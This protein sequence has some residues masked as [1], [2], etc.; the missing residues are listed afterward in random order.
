M[1]DLGEEICFKMLLSISTESPRLTE[2]SG[3]YAQ[4][5]GKRTECGSSW[6][7]LLSGSQMEKHQPYKHFLMKTEWHLKS[8]CLFWGKQGN[9]LLKNSSGWFFWKLFWQR[10]ETWIPNPPHKYLLAKTGHRWEKR[11]AQAPRGSAAA[12]WGAITQI[13]STDRIS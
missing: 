13:Y 7:D 9:L 11:P 2:S 10:N 3:S 4:R 8:T 6:W 5:C 12:R 1:A